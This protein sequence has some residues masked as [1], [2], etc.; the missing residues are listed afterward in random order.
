MRLTHSGGSPCFQ[1]LSSA[2]AKSTETGMLSPMLETDTFA[3]L[4]R[5]FAHAV[6]LFV[7]WGTATG[8]LAAGHAHPQHGV[9]TK[10]PAKSAR[11]APPAPRLTVEA[12]NDARFPRVAPNGRLP[13][14][15]LVRTQIL[16]DRAHFSPG[17]VDGTGGSNLQK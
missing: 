13:A 4:R 14:A 17:E 6:L 12:I 10:H 16:L 5:R 15:A 8:T 7:A 2:P 3:H 11:H 1:V 9:A